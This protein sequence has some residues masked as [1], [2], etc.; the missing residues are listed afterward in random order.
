VPLPLFP[1]GTTALNEARAFARRAAALDHPCAALTTTETL[2]PGTD[3]R[4]IYE[5]VG[6]TALPREQEG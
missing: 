5:P 6:T 2:F 1:V 3:P 4:L